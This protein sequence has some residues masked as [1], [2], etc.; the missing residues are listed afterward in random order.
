MAHPEQ[1]PRPVAL[2]G[3]R[4]RVHG[5]AS[6]RHD[7]HHR[8]RE[9]GVQDGDRPPPPGRRSARP[10]PV[11]GRGWPHGAGR[12]RLG[13]GHHVR[14]RAVDRR[15][16]RGRGRHVPGRRRAVRH[17]VR[18]RDG[19]VLVQ[20]GPVRAGRDHGPADHL[21]GVPGG[22]PEAEGRRDHPARP[23]RRRQVAGHVLVGVPRAAHRRGRTRCCR[24]ARTA[25]STPSRSSRPVPSSSGSSRWTRS[26]TASWPRCGTAPA[27]R[28]RRSPPRTRRCT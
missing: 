13:P 7:R 9:R 27:G 21:G 23:R 12:R 3:G 22:R 1:R 26:R 17:P 19:R 20:Q 11:V 2:A 28:R 8:L 24:P 10:L 25:R 15:P 14:G 5:R 16:Q 4:R 6:E 18:P